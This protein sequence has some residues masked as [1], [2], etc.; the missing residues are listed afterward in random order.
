[1][2][3]VPKQDSSKQ[4]ASRNDIAEAAYLLAKC[5]CWSARELG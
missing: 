4:S 5:F 2:R 3:S 1:M